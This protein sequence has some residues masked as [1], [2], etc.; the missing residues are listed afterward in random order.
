MAIYRISG[1][2]VNIA[3]DGAAL[4]IT[5]ITES[6]VDPGVEVALLAGSG[7][8]DA[9]MAVVDEAAAGASF[10]TTMIASVL[11]IVGLNGL[12]ISADADEEGVQVEFAQIDP[13]T[14][15][16]ESGSVH[17]RGTFANGLLYPTTISADQT[18]GATIELALVATWDGTDDPLVVTATGSAGTYAGVSE[19]YVTGPATVNGADVGG[20]LS[21]TIDFG[22]TVEKHR[23]NGEKWA[24]EAWITQRRPTITIQTPNAAIL[25]TLSATGAPIASSTVVYLRQ[26]AATAAGRVA[27]ATETHI[28]FTVNEGHVHASPITGSHGAIVGAEIVITPTYDET[29][30]LFVVDTTAAI[31]TP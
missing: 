4:A 10:T 29:N 2:D 27:D 8:P 18:P 20:V 26:C 6:S 1:V 31:V 17:V 9:T 16:V 19:A 13:L 14:S 12:P 22:I 11:G 21:M 15:G 7:Q 30:A 3:G 23:V 28:S 24:R 25:N 5:Q